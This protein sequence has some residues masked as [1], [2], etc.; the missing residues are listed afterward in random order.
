MSLMVLLFFSIDLIFPDDLGELPTSFYH[1][2]DYVNWLW[3]LM[4]ALSP[5]FAAKVIGL[6]GAQ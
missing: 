6:K 5:C 1:C 4:R 3:V 2:L